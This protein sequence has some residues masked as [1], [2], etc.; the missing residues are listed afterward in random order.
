MDVAQLHQLA[1]E[2]KVELRLA[3]GMAGMMYVEFGYVEG[4]DPT[5]LS[6]GWHYPTVQACYMVNLHEIGHGALGHTQGRPPATDQTF[7]FDNG[8]LR[9]EAQ[10]WE[11]ALDHM[12]EEL[13]MTTRRFMWGTC[14]GS[15]YAGARAAN[16]RGGNRLGNGNRHHVA[17]TYDEPDEYFWGIAD[18]LLPG[19]RPVGEGRWPR[20]EVPSADTRAIR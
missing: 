5:D 12:D 3:P 20:V 18:R 13:E 16:G 6:C 19:V 8:V 15:Y 2:A 9:S 17:F 4:P 1:K 11:Y 10:A 14:L 7:Y